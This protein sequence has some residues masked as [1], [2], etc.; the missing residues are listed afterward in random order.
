MGK[1]LVVIDMQNDFIDGALANPDGQAIVESMAEF[2]HNWDGPVYYTMDTH[3]EDYLSTREG[4]YLPI[5]HCIYCTHGFLINDTIN[6]ALEEKNAKVFKKITFGSKYLAE[7]LFQMNTLAPCEGEPDEI[8]FCGL[9]T[10][11][12]VVANIVLVKTLL[13]EANIYMI[14]NLCAG[15][16]KEKH[17]AT[18]EVLKSLQVE[19]VKAENGEVK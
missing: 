4:K 3:F 10:D 14:E 11:I 2:I 5:P 9:C 8:Y 17:N 18:I 15:T 1:I 7:Y 13:P 6:K 16:T 12:C 19:I